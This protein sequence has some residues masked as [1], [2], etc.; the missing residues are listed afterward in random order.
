[1]N[2]NQLQYTTYIFGNEKSYTIMTGA[3]FLGELLL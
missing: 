3:S 2:K 1:M